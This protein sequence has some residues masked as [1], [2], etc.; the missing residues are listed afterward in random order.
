MRRDNKYKLC[1]GLNRWCGEKEQDEGGEAEDEGG[2]AIKVRPNA[3]QENK[4]PALGATCRQ[5]LELRWVDRGWGQVIWCWA[6]ALTELATGTS[7]TIHWLAPPENTYHPYVVPGRKRGGG[8]A[9]HAPQLKPLPPHLIFSFSL[10]LV[11]EICLVQCHSFRQSIEIPWRGA[12]CEDSQPILSSI[13]EAKYP[14]Q[15]SIW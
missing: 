15:M 13:G 4:Q 7:P 1:D 9:K 5:K 10:H 11:N 12:I 8:L 2:V 3:K 6:L 14:V